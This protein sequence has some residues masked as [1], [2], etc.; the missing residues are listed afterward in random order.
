MRDPHAL[1]QYFLCEDV[2]N[3]IGG[4]F[5]PDPAGTIMKTMN[6]SIQGGSSRR[7]KVL[8]R[9][10]NCVIQ[11]DSKGCSYYSSCS[12]RK[13]SF[14]SR[15]RIYDAAELKEADVARIVADQ[16]NYVILGI[17]YITTADIFV[18]DNRVEVRVLAGSRIENSSVHKGLDIISTSGSITNYAQESNYTKHLATLL[19][20]LPLPLV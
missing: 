14:E 4:K 16:R 8:G 9:L 19:L 2:E 6:I 17:G 18:V 12:A 10:T 15:N 1:E 13:G 7:Q 20:P 11:S 5:V 3:R